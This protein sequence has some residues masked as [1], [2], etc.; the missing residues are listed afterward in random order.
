MLQKTPYI[1]VHIP[2]KVTRGDL[3]EIYA[4]FLDKDTLTPVRTSNIYL[5]IIS[6]NDHE[7]WSTRLMNQNSSTLHIA[8]GTAEMKDDNYVVKIADHK[9]M[10]EFGFNKLQVKNPR[11]IFQN[12]KQRVK[13][14]Q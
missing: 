11:K 5:Q 6:T 8:V 10:M 3:M 9:E 2:K 14:C 7:Y 12:K 13:I 1:D 4:R